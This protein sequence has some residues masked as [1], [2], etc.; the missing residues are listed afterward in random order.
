MRRCAN[1]QDVGFFDVFVFCSKP[2]PSILGEEHT[3]AQMQRHCW[4]QL[5]TNLH[6]LSHSARFCVTT[7]E[8]R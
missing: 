8:R 1:L 2:V 5:F 6:L 7:D 3:L 4:N